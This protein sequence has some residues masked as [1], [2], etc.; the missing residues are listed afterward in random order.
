MTLL[1][2]EQLNMNIQIA[3]MLNLLKRY[4]GSR[5]TTS[6]GQSHNI[7]QS[8]N[9]PSPKLI[10][11]SVGVKKGHN[12]TEAR[13]A[14][15]LLNCSDAIIAESRW[16]SSDPDLEI[17]QVKCKRKSDLEGFVVLTFGRS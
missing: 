1:E 17:Q 13:N 9:I 15:Y 6:E 8:N 16:D 5:A 10:L 14:C 11:Q 3:E 4:L 7:P 12:F 2:E